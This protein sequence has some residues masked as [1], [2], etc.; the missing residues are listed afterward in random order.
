MI[1][2]KLASLNA[3]VS[4]ARKSTT[5]VLCL[6]GIDAP[7]VMD[8][9]FVDKT[10]DIRFSPSL[11]AAKTERLVVKQLTGSEGGTFL[12]T[13]DHRQHARAA[14][15]HSSGHAVPALVRA[16]FFRSSSAP[17]YTRALCLITL[18]DRF[19]FETKKKT[20]TSFFRSH[21]RVGKKCR[22]RRV[23]S[24]VNG[25]GETKKYIRTY[26]SVGVESCCENRTVDCQIKT[27]GRDVNRTR[28]FVRTCVVQIRV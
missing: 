11:N 23:S 16:S 24:N 14:F 26:V 13:S 25:G 5:N 4:G 19:V 27:M 21:S 9:S 15:Y 22:V 2:Q 7:A 20:A 8:V 28:L 17:P 6:T 18:L 10:Y 3:V 1:R 12:E